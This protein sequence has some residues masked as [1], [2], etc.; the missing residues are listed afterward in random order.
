[1]PV[2]PEAGAMSSK[3][4]CQCI[5][6]LCNAMILKILR[7]VD[8][9]LTHSCLLDVELLAN[10]MPTKVCVS[11]QLCM[12]PH[13]VH[14]TSRE[15]KRDIWFVWKEIAFWNLWCILCAFHCSRSQSWWGTLPN[16]EECA[17]LV[18]VQ[19]CLFFIATQKML[20]TKFCNDWYDFFVCEPKICYF[21]NFA[22]IVPF[23]L[24]E[25]NNWVRKK[26]GNNR[27]KIR[28]IA[29]FWIRKQKIVPIIAKFGC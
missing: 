23:F 15:R 29:C 1:M 14:H 25:P 10:K 13:V 18:Q 22:T 11:A 9:W 3:L 6:P 24:G 27:C 16:K 12:R 21:P 26:K 5:T 28:K 7:C 4:T 17:A 8:W 19:S 20:T 2:D